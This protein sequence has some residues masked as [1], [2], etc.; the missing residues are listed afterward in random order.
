MWHKLMN[1]QSN[2]PGNPK[3]RQEKHHRK[4][5]KDDSNFLVYPIN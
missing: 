4:S 5:P 2:K 1:P 3:E